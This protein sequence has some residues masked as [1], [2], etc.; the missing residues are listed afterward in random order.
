MAALLICSFVGFSCGPKNPPNGPQ[1]SGSGSGSGSGA[2]PSDNGLALSQDLPPGLDLRLSDGKSGPP[3]ADHNKLP[4]AA[5]I[6]D[7][8]AEQVLARM[9]AIKSDAA[10]QKDFAI[11]AGSQ[12]PP[13][14]GKT[15]TGSFPP[16]GGNAPPP[17]ATSD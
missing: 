7:A 8:D 3:A 10:D 6:S 16:P 14:T 1:T 5:K 4:P 9:P 15:V 12:P 2:G 11:R 13:R 17:T